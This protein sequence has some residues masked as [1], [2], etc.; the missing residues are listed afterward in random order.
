MFTSIK[1]AQACDQIVQ[2][3]EQMISDGTLNVGDR[4]PSERALAIQ[5][6]VSRMTLRRAIQL[7]EGR[8]LVEARSGRGTF[9]SRPCDQ[10]LRVLADSDT[11]GKPLMGN[12]R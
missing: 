2:Q 8:G 5:F 1:A 10:L 7:L 4:L 12:G 6:G 9:V 11:S 3:I